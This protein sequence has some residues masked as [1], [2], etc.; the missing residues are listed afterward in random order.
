MIAF[1][2]PD[3]L[4]RQ[5][6]SVGTRQDELA[7]RWFKKIERNQIVITAVDVT[8]NPAACLCKR[9][10]EA[11]T[12]PYYDLGSLGV[13]SVASHIIKLKATQPVDVRLV[14]I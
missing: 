3:R 8:P 5:P 14:L 6:Q 1:G 12:L 10:S 13:G 7:D 9:R 4:Y 11:T 2:Y